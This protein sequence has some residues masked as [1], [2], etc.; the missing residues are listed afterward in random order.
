[1]TVKYQVLSIRI[2]MFPLIFV[3]KVI[4]L[5]SNAMSIML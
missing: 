1:M 5:V 4:K 2:F 3:I